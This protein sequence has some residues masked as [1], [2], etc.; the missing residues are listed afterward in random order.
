MSLSLFRIRAPGPSARA[1]RPR[2]PRPAFTLIELLV[3]LA[4]IALLLFLLLPAVQAVREAASRTQC[5]NN[6]KQ[7]SL[8]CLN[9]E[10][11][12]GR[13]PTGGWGFFWNG[14]PDRGSDRRQ[15][16]GWAYNVLPFVEQ[17]NL[18]RMGAGLPDAQKRAAIA[19]RLATPLAL[20]NCPTRRKGGPW[21]KSNSD[22][23]YDC[24]APALLARS[25]YAANAGD[26]AADE[27]F[28]GPGSLAEGDNPGFN[29]PSTDG[30]TG[31]LFQR[32]EI[33]FKDITRG[34]SNV[35]LLGE[36]YLNP[37][38][39]FTGRDYADNES[40]YTGFNNDNYRTT[41]DPPQRD[42]RGYANTQ[43]F[44]SAH[45]AVAHM[46][47]CDGSVRAVPFSVDPE[48]HRMAGSRY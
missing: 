32:S 39:Y 18:Y 12:Y 13:L 29:W 34:S 14:D 47:Y 10:S 20:F 3:V 16:G 43:V 15:T 27:F 2:P 17:D 6:L 38:D 33:R 35:Y 28:G 7:L 44:G 25:D 24:D 9:H 41:H 19:Q 4:I 22:R 42:T 5:A 30:L 46:A 37:A 1:R 11:T 48:V 36:K 8:A 23:Y 21:P 40:L 45:R 26:Q 31:V